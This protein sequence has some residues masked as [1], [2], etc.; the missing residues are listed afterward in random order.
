MPE[1]KK[2]QLAHTTIDFL[3]Y[4][5]HRGTFVPNQSSIKNILDSPVAKNVKNMQR[6][7]GTVNVCKKCPSSQHIMSFTNQPSLKGHIVTLDGCL[8][9]CCHTGEAYFDQAACA[10]RLQLVSAVRFLLRRFT[11]RIRRGAKAGRA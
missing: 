3:R 2:C 8:E 1:V 7:L 11:K 9:Q 5:V 10:V 6:F 4:T